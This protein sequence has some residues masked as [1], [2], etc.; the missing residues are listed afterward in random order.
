MLEMITD[1]VCGMRVETAEASGAS[2]YER[3][4]YHFCSELCKTRFDAD[5]ERYALGA[6]LIDARP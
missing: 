5:P 3:H 2:R 1:P 4:T 6:G